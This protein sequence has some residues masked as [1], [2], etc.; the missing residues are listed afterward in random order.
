MTLAY[1]L[2]FVLAAAVFLV[3]A[4]CRKP[5]RLGWSIGTFVVLAAILTL[6]ILRIGDKPAA[7][8][9]T[10]T[11]EQLKQRAGKQP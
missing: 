8:A 11:P 1:V 9:V 6:A 7:G 4:K 3:T 2:S 10:V 5:I